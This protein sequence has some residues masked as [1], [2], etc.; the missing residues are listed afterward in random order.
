[1]L[2]QLESS[3]GFLSS[4]TVIAALRNL[5]F[6]ASGEMKRMWKQFLRLQLSQKLECLDDNFCEPQLE[7]LQ[8]WKERTIDTFARMVLSSDRDK[9]PTEVRLEVGQWSHMMDQWLLNDFAR[10]RIAS[11]FNVVVEFPDSMPALQDLQICLSRSEQNEALQKELV[12]SVRRVLASKLQHAGAQTEDVLVI[13][14]GTIRSLCSIF[15]KNEAAAVVSSV[16][17]DTIE[18]LRRRKDSVSAVVRCVMQPSSESLLYGEL[19]GRTKSAQEDD[20]DTGEEWQRN[21]RPDVLGILLSALSVGAISQEYRALLSHDLLD[22]T[23]Y[24]VD[25]EVEALERMNCIFGEEALASCSVMVRDVQESRRLNTRIHQNQTIVANALMVSAT[26]WPALPSEKYKVHQKL[27]GYMESYLEGFRKLKPNQRLVYLNDYGKV[28]ISLDQ[29]DPQTKLVSRHSFELPLF[30]A[31][32]VMHLVDQCPDTIDAIAAKMETTSQ[33]IKQ[34]IQPHVPTLL[35]V[36][37]NGQLS[38]QKQVVTG[39]AF[40]FSEVEGV[41]SPGGGLSK[42]EMAMYSN[43]I[44]AMLKTGG[45]KTLEQIENSMKMFGKFQGTSAQVRSIL[46]YYVQEGKLTIDGPSF[47]IVKT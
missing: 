19:H 36:G 21:G 26:C 5:H 43:M 13:V 14:V 24:N 37:P 27:N 2:A 34:R 47:A 41:A 32:I 15:S 44:F 18:H 33:I 12:Q 39:L 38:L 35:V 22:K 46:D 8:E 20:D 40:T 10:K 1:M 25:A 17:S 30:L 45:K 11:F 29:A 9:Q 31:S 3:S 4:D 6:S 23:D 28:T 7:G 42:E 16:V